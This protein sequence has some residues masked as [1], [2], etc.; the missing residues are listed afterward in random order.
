MLK[1]IKHTMETIDGVS[2]Y[3]IISFLIF[4]TCFVAVLVY[5]F[6]KSPQSIEEVSALPLDNDQQAPRHEKAQ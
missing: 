3:P 5:A 6:R 1:F 2:I 4:F